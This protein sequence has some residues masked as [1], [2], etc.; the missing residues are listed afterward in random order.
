M[1]ST[2]TI[3]IALV[4]TLS[5]LFALGLAVYYRRQSSRLSAKLST[6]LEKLATAHRD[7]QQME[8]RYE[9]ISTFNNNLNEAELTTRLQRSRLSAQHGSNQTSAPER[10]LYL[11]SLAESGMG[12]DEIA[13]ILSISTQEAEQLV[14]LS[15][16][17][18]GPS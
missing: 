16:L 17:A 14:K 18:S 7:V 13:A 9:E 2:T 15:S 1:T 6:A 4:A 10:Y 8:A 3:G 5:A 11:R 12:A